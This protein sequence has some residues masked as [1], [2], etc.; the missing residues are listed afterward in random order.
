MRTQVHTVV[1]A[2]VLATAS[3]LVGP[4]LARAQTAPPP[5]VANVHCTM[6]YTLSGWSVFYKKAKGTAN[7]SCTNGQTATV[8]IRVAGGGLSF[9]KTDV[10]GTGTFSVVRGINEIFGTY[11]ASAAHGG[12]VRTG[13]AQ[14]MTK[15]DVSLGLTATGRGFDVG[16]YFG[17]FII[18][19]WH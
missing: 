2:A 13:E 11:G 4:A 6:T 16:F 14:A 5:A 9:G 15:G 18:E 7:V 19:P 3:L 17:K 12:V 8:R 10:Q 1:L